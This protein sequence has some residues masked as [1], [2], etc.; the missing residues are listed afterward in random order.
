M[1][2]S[3]DGL[4]TW[5]PSQSQ[6]PSTNI[7]SVVATST[8]G[9]GVLNPPLSATNS[10]L[11]VVL[12]GSLPPDLSD[13]SLVLTSASWLGHGQFQFFFNSAAG[14]EYVVQSSS[15][16]IDW[17]TVQT[18]SGTGASLSF[19]DTNALGGSALYYRIKAGNP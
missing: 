8:G 17:N 10:F 12:E 19:T 5:T 14:M 11:V 6:A 2:I 7:V 18:M 15:N 4:I 9:F 3:S 13:S 16:L 1:S